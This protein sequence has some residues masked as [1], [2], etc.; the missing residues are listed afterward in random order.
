MRTGHLGYWGKKTK[1]QK[2][3]TNQQIPSTLSLVR[4]KE[5]RVNAP[6]TRFRICHK[7]W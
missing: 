4:G 1:K 5:D 3:T 2:P 6:K 7:P